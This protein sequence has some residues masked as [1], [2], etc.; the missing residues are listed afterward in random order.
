MYNNIVIIIRMIKVW[1]HLCIIVRTLWLNLY[2]YISE[3]TF[4]DSLNPYFDT[5]YCWEF[6][7]HVLPFCKLGHLIICENSLS[8]VLILWYI[9]CTSFY[10]LC[11]KL[12]YG[13]LD[14]VKCFDFVLLDLMWWK[15][16]SRWWMGWA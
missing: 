7:L 9:I 6:Y 5:Y 12:R 15:S 10:S 3:I 16:W 1:K 2:I 14:L 8:V 13:L 11:W 4:Q